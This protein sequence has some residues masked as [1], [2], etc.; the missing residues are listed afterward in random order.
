ML[1]KYYRITAL[2][3]GLIKTLEAQGRETHWD[4]VAND[5]PGAWRKFV[6]Q[7]FGSL[8]PNP[9]DYDIRFSHTKSA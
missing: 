8:A 5:L 4:I 6:C 3:E 1:L 2:E 7:R 9:S